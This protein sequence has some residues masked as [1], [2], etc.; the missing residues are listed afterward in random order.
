MGA[1][2]TSV[3]A[4]LLSWRRKANMPRII[5]ALR[6]QTVDVEVWLINNDGH[7]SFGADRVIAIPWN[8]GEWARYVFAGRITTEYGMF[9]DDDFMLGDPHYLEDAIMLHESMC[10]DHILGIA[11]RGLQTSSPYY[12]PDIIRQNAYAAILK[13]HFQLFKSDIVRRVRIP[14]HPSASDIYWSLDSGGGEARHYVSKELSE[15]LVTLERHGVGY[16]FR[17][18]HNKERNEVCAAWLQEAAIRA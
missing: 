1:A 2:M 18:G 16:E 15:R 9:Q 17:P 8:A 10:P 5:D 13:G 6:S 4:V 11:G 7:E 14:R 3:T 12:A